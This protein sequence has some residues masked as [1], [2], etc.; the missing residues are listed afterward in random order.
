MKVTPR[1]VGLLSLIALI[2]AAAFIVFNSEWIAAVTLVNVLIIT[3]SLALA[4][5]P[6]EHD[7]ED[8]DTHAN[9][10]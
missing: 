4:L 2:P 5:S 6:H 1:L 8:Y 7:Q 10:A 9:G 3:G